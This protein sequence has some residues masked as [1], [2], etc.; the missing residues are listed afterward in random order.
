MHLPSV[1]LIVL[2]SAAFS[3]PACAT[4]TKGTHEDVVINSEP[5]GASVAAIQEIDPKAMTV[6]KT[7]TFTCPETP[8]KLILPRVHGARVTVDKPGYD[9]I[10][11]MLTSNRATS[12]SSIPTGT[13]IAGLPDGSHVIAGS[14]DLIK[15]VP[16]SVTASA[17]GLF[18]LGA[19]VVVD[20]ATGANLS[21][22]PNPVTVFLAAEETPQ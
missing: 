16:V 8:C 15:R 21:L 22:T 10:T 5:P 19:G 1:K 4:I 12:A 20:V 11:F 13:L 3:L 17:N 9:A 14:P 18:T 6:R 2:I 7:G